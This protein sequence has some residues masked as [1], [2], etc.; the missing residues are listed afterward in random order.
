MIYITESQQSSLPRLL[1]S[2]NIHDSLIVATALLFRDVLKK[3]VA[4]VTKDA[5]IIQC[6]II[7]T[8]W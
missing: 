2:L 3:D 6:G 8:L 4:L 5:D 1:S 7:K